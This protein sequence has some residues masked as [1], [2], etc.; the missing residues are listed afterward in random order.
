MKTVPFVLILACCLCL[1]ACQKKA[2]VNPDD[3]GYFEEQEKQHAEMR[4]VSVRWKQ[5]HDVADFLSLKQWI[6]KG[7][8]P[9][10]VKEVLG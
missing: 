4:K 3:S 1:P 9:K 6:Q 8:I 10:F 2:E 7:A 5:T